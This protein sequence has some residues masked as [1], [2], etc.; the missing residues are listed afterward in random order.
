MCKNACKVIV[1]W[2]CHSEANTNV[3]IRLG[4]LEESQTILFLFKTF[5]TEDF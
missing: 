1:I 4:V 2:G 3:T 5:L